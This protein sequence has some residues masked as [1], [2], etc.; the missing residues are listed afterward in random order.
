[1]RTILAG[2]GT[3]ILGCFATVQAAM[4]TTKT[5][6]PVLGYSKGELMG[7][8]KSFGEGAA[9]RRTNEDNT[10]GTHT[11]KTSKT[12]K[13]NTEGEKERRPLLRGGPGLL[14]ACAVVPR[15][16]LRLGSAAPAPLPGSALETLAANASHYA[17]YALMIVMP[18]TGIAMGYFGGKGLP[19]FGYAIPGASKENV[20]GAIAGNAFWVHK[21]AGQV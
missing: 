10:R 4:A 9:S 3:G 19:F 11:Q 14:I 6:K 20:N 15:I 2:V 8:H 21:Q 13:Q 7:L 17:Q 12:R 18:G 1:M 16:A 5:Y